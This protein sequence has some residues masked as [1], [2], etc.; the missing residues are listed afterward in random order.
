MEEGNVRDTGGKER[1][2]EGMVEAKRDERPARE[3]LSKALMTL[4]RACWQERQEK[5]K[6]R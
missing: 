2:S 5:W 3:T 6:E 4:E 1:E